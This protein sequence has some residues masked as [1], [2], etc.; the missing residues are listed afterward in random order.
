MNEKIEQ[1]FGGMA[2]NK[3]LVADLKLRE[4]R[5]IPSF[6]EEWLV[7]K[8]YDPAEDQG[9]TRKKITKF[10]SEHLPSKNDKEHIKWKLNSGHEMVLLDKF[11]VRTDLKKGVTFVTIPS[12]DLNDGLVAEEVILSC[13]EILAGGQWGAGR[14]RVVSHGKGKAVK[15][16]DFKPMQSGKIDLEQM[17]LARQNFSTQEWIDLLVRTMGCEPNAYGDRQ[18][19]YLILRLLPMVQNNLNMIELAPKGTGKSFIFSNLSRY[20]WLNSGGALSEAQ[21]FY[22]L[23][24]KQLGLMATND[25][26]VLDEGQSIQFKGENDIHAKFKAYLESGEFSRGGEKVTSE[27]GLMILANIELHN[28]QPT[29]PDYIRELPKMFHDDALLD[30]FHGILPG[31]EIPRFSKDKITTGVG[32]K[33]DAF[34]EYLHQL[35]SVSDMEFPYGRIPMLGGDIR[36]T[37][38]I[39]RTSSALSKLLMLNPEDAD[40]EE[41]VLKP[42]ME[43]R[44]MVRRQISFMNPS[45]FSPELN[46]SI[47]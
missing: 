22:N 23:S 8:F 39:E 7:S 45:E 28:S 27:C 32:L 44:A 4:S 26:L 10:M 9:D 41:Y 11:S 29:R 5:T 15:L 16:I 6:V 18:K 24:S 47:I 40:Y 3:K 43:L 37:K 21:L 12:I 42:A 35:R 33:A 14:L 19:R 25:V 38:A 34:G 36:D 2:I 30:R 20:V 17:V 46:V 31:W 1:Y 13:P